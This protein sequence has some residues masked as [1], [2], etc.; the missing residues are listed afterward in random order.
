VVLGL[1]GGYTPELLRQIRTD[2][3]ALPPGAPPRAA[4][5]EPPQPI[6]GLQV[7]I[8]ER[9]APATAI[10]IGFPIPLLR[11]QPDWYPLALANSWLGEHRHESGQL[12]QVIRELRGLNYGD[13]SYLEHFANGGELQFPQPGDGRRQQ[14]FELWLRSVPHEA[15]HFTLRAA[16]REL[17][18][19]VDHG[20]T[21]EQFASKKSALGKYVLHFAPTTMDRLGYALDDQ[22]YGIP[23][24]HLDIYRRRMNGMTL[25]EVNAAVKKYLQYENMQIVIVTKD[26]RSLREA[27][28]ADRPSL[29]KYPASRPAEVLKEDE[30]ISRFPLHIRR[31]NVRIVPVKELF[32]KGE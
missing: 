27:L 29:I 20:L 30:E 10:S 16:L 14:I 19:L 31:E 6:H 8:V 23:G 25:A 13:Y 4:R 2:L 32:E 1:G 26:A 15:A 3:A 21:E 28:V 9:D 18:H 7:T 22:F 5:P 24:S 11:G 17:R 12:Y